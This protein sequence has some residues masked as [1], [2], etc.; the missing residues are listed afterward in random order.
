MIASRVR[1]HATAL[2]LLE[3]AQAQGRVAHAYAFVGPPGIGK[4]LVALAFAQSLLCSRPLR[5]VERTKAC[6]QCPACMRVE[7]GSHPDLMLLAPTPPKDNPRGNVAIRLDAIRELERLAA[8]RPAEGPWKVFIIDDAERMTPETPQAFLKTLEE[9]PDRTVLVLILAQLRAL[10]PTVLSRC[11]VVRFAPLTETE[12]AAVLREHGADDDTARFL[13]RACQGRVGLALAR[14]ARAWQAERDGAVALLR[15]IS[16]EGSEAL[17]NQV[18]AL[19]RDRSQVAELTE[20]LW[21]WH[22]DLLC[23]KAGGDPRLVMASDSLAELSRAAEATSLEAIV[24]ALVACREAW[25]AL[26]GNV[27]PRLTL[28]VL[29]SRL[30]LK[31]A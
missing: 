21:L 30:A 20:A 11:Q 26:Q 23:V 6:G 10:P 28:E 29:L 31:A 5:E 15:K 16:A 7:R 8:L 2:E 24:E 12:V 27:S 22:R 4:K 3:R 18:E 1:G 14:D 19:G 25:Q 13:A 9:P 17:F